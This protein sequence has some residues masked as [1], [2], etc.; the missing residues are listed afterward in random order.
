MP[1]KTRFTRYSAYLLFPLAASAPALLNAQGISPDFSRLPQ[2][3]VQ[4]QA[5]G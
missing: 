1:M 5:G 3:R 2:I 4:S